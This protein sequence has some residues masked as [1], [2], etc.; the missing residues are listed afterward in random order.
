MKTIFSRY[1]AV[2][3]SDGRPMPVR[4]ALALIN[5]DLDAFFTEQEMEYGIWHRGNGQTGSAPDP[6]GL[7]LLITCYCCLVPAEQ[8]LRLGCVRPKPQGLGNGQTGNAPD[9]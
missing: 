4:A 9:P 3:E 5:Q 1:R 7:T 6:C 8:S 2:L